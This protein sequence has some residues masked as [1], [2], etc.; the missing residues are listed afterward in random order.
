MFLFN[1]KFVCLSL[2][3]LTSQVLWAQDIQRNI[4]YIDDSAS[5]YATKNF[6][7]ASFAWGTQEIGSKMCEPAGEELTPS[8]DKLFTAVDTYLKKEKNR[9]Q[10]LSYGIVRNPQLN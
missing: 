6:E 1:K 5:S 2:V 7:F 4:L 9:D 10:V 8:L 3:A